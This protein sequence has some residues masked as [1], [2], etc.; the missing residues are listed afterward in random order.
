ML[1]AGLISNQAG[2]GGGIFNVGILTVK[3]STIRG[4][5]TK[6]VGGGV[7]NSTI[8]VSH[9]EYTTVNENTSASGGG[10][11][12]VGRLTLDNSTVSGNTGTR[13]GGVLNEGYIRIS[14]TTVS[15]NRGK[16]GGGI[17]VF[18]PSGI[19]RTELT[20]T[21]I[22][23]NQASLEGADCRGIITSL[24]HNLVGSGDHCGMQATASDLV[25][26]SSQPVDPRL[27]ALENN[28]GPTETH[29]LLSGSPAIDTGGDGPDLC[30]ISFS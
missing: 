9:L 30:P 4:N 21:I 6:H 1:D 19:P 18:Q 10:I 11:R 22:A 13:G 26:T 17:A 14:N 20:N 12:N 5:V 16:Y 28:G 23:A 25:G 7:Q 15:G 2:S 3:R 8:G 24:G 27:G 29:A